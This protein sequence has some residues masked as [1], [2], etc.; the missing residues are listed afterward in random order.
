MERTHKQRCAVIA[1]GILLTSC[2]YA[3]ALDPSL[4]ISQYAHTAWKIREGFAKGTIKT[5]AQTPDGYLWFGTEFGLYRFDGVR[6]VLWQPR[7]NVQLPSSLIRKLLVARN[8]TLWIGTHRGLASWQD[9]KLTRFPEVPAQEVDSLLEDREGTVWAG[10]ETIPNWRLCAIRRLKVQ[11]YGEKNGLGLG[12]GSLFEDRNGNL[13]A[14]TGT[15]LWRWK[16]GVPKLIP[17][18]GPVS[19]IHALIEDSDGEL[20]ISTRAGMMRL[21]DGKAIPYLLSYNGPQFNPH[22]L[23]RDSNGGLWIGTIDRGLLHVHQG[24]TDRF[25]QADG[26][27]SDFVEDVFED[28]EGNV[29]VCTNNGL[30][31]FRDFPVTVIPVKQG[32]ATSYVESVLPS[33]DGSVWLGT[34]HGLDRWKDGVVTLYRKRRV[35]VLETERE[36]VDRGLPDDY[37]GSLYEDHRGRIWVFSRSGAAYLEKGR[38]IPVS[39]MPG[40]YAHAIV[41]DIAGDL[42]ISQDQGLFHVMRG[43][44]V[45]RLPWEGLGPRGLALALGADGSHGGV[46]LGFSQGGVA[47][48]KDGQVGTSYSGAD[49]L[50]EGRISSVQLDQSGILWVGTESGLSRVKNGRVAT[51]NVQNG[52]PCD[53]VHEVVEDDTHAFWLYMACGLVRIARPEL[54]LWVADSKRSIHTMV[55]DNSDGLRSTALAGA[56]SPRV[57][58]AKDG[59][60]WYVSEGNV[61]VI[62][63]RRLDRRPFSF[64]KLPPPVVIEQIT[65]NG[66]TYEPDRKLN[67]PP[68]VR[69]L[70]IDYTALS[71]VAPEK[72][73]FRYK[74]EGQDSDWREVVNDRRVQYSNLAPGNHRFRVTACNNSGVWNEEG[75][76]LD[77]AIAPAYYQTNWFRAVCGITFLAM[78]WT[79]FQLR[80]RSLERRHA[81]IERHRTEVRAL[82]EQLIKAQE[83][84]R[85]RISGELHDGV[86]QQ[87]TSL[88]LR[89]GK[90]RNQVAPD[91]EAKATVSGLQQELIKIGTDIRHISHELHPALLQESGLPA[92]LSSHCEDFGKVRGLSVTCE[93]DP[94]VGELSPGAA[95]CLYRIAQEALGNAAKYSGAKKIEVRLTRSNGSVCLSV[96]DDGVG[97]IPEEL[98]G[99]GGLGVINMRERVLQLHGTFEFKS[100]PRR[101][102]IVKAEV[103]FRPA[104]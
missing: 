39:G 100:A 73:R 62:D 67:L 23:L 64:N 44:G 27:S 32:L 40:G 65:V 66:K 36:I 43:C 19:E 58:K 20:L 61:F 103:P 92:A 95:L 80:V 28:R 78:L 55:L 2:V 99:S 101:G 11:C 45:E 10:V 15:G 60:L 14:G 82:N 98:K 104:S 84:E 88:T 3:S 38:F 48:F 41:E 1:L 18:S 70:T 8:G 33:A 9:G 42:W 53:S 16:P 74:L 86:L 35:P 81:V 50:G 59:R 7:G 85:M 68:L 4:D 21:V 57:G 29:W 96:S 97:C 30:D 69:D 13:W 5:I 63:P 26:L 31:R 51:L 34:R 12:V 54:D 49:G 75:A 56:L 47:H 6:T 72:V 25:T 71:F 52:M 94:S 89:L 90:I 24:R 91:P 87:I 17:L 22:W 76:V 83:A 93:T 102:T 79:V 46:W 37:Q 77:F